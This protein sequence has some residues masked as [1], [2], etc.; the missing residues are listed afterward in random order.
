MLCN[1]DNIRLHASK[2]GVFVKDANSTTIQMH[3]PSEEISCWF[4][5]QQMENEEEAPE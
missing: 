3:V 1:G 2:T 4:L 5:K